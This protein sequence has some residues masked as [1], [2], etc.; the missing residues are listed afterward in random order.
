MIQVRYPVRLISLLPNANGM[1][2]D[3][4]TAPDPKRWLDTDEQERLEWMQD[5]AQ[6]YFGDPDEDYIPLVVPMLIVENQL[7]IGE[8]AEAGATMGRL[9][10]AG[11]DRLAALLA[12]GDVVSV[13]TRAALGGGSAEASDIGADLVERYAALDAEKLKAEPVDPRLVLD[14]WIESG[15]ESDEEFD[16]QRL[17]EFERRLFDRV[18]AFDEKN[19]RLLDDFAERNAGTDAMGF[20]EAAGFFFGLHAC[21]DM[22]M[23]SE[24]T[25]IVQG[26]AIFEDEREARS[27]LNARMALYNWVSDAFS[28]DTPAIPVEC[29]PRPDPMED[30]GTDTAFKK[31][32]RGASIADGWLEESWEAAVSPGSEEEKKLYEARMTFAFF[33]DREIADA[34]VAELGLEPEDFET[35]VR[36]FRFSALDSIL[37][38]QE[39]GLGLRRSLSPPQR[40][41]PAR[42]EKIGR[43]QP[44]PC[45]SGKK[46]K[47]CCGGPRQVH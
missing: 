5:W 34:T 20:A 21:P 39:F 41:E 24:W 4:A 40:R 25:E 3:P 46:Y 16:E 23:P 10:A 26:D 17:E 42:R 45:G 44:C 32:C 11:L 22:V 1:D 8:P 14:G 29:R 12:M 37:D 47:K 33:A 7:A 13:A 30:V 18:P 38:Y 43:N 36:S 19:R 15:N 9:E 2:Y 31:W 28:S 27:I 35:V 6:T